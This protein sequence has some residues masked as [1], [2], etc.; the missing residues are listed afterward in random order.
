MD[1]QW[2][3]KV[4]VI[5]GA[6]SGF[7][8]GVAR[9]FAASGASLVLAARRELLL[10]DLANEC[11]SFGGKALPVPT[12][13]SDDEDVRQLADAAL[14]RFGKVDVWINNAGVGVIGRFE[15]IPLADHTQ[16][17][18]TN[19]LGTIY[20]SHFALRQ[21]HRQGHGVLINVASALGKIPAP[22]YASYAASKY[23]VVGFDAALRQE[24]R[25]N[26]VRDIHVCTILPMAMDTPFFDHASNYTGHQAVPVPPLYDPQLV[27]DAIYHVAGDPEEEMIVGMAGRVT[28]V[29]HHVL[30]SAAE[31]YMG[32]QTH[33][34]QMEDAPPAPKSPGAV[35]EPMMTGTDVSAGRLEK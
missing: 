28:N 5:T 12:D 7:G 19:L 25:E 13:V 1:R 9:K 3:G 15:D 30:P 34:S 4:V 31:K 16:M 29:L 35:H 22:Y 8:K 10:Q 17:V 24:L 2:S 23:G 26:D 27:I 18:E 14:V 32:R 11:E 21:F 20:G 6:S 33:K